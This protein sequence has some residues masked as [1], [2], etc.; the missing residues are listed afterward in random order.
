MSN[1]PQIDEQD[2]GQLE[3]QD[4]KA[5]LRYLRRLSGLL[6][7]VADGS[8]VA[9]P[10]ETRLRDRV[11]DEDT[12]HRLRRRGWVRTTPAHV[13]RRSMPHRA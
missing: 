13:A 2:Y 1:A 4:G 12:G 5:T 3:S 6:Q 11:G 9:Q 7:R 10:G 8:V